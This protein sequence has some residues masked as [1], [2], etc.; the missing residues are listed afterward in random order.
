MYSNITP[1]ELLLHITLSM[2]LTDVLVEKKKPDTR[3]Y[4]FSGSIYMILKIRQN[5]SMLL[6]VRSVEGWVVP[7]WAHKGYL[8][9]LK[10]SVS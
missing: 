3:E 4:K 6:E 1:N 9:S 2:D 10:C 8:R 5:S 7:G